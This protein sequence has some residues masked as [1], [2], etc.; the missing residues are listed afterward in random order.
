[1]LEYTLYHK[2]INKI[3]CKFHLS[4]ANPVHM[5]YTCFSFIVSCASLLYWHGHC[6]T[7]SYERK[8]TPF[9]IML[10]YK[11]TQQQLTWRHFRAVIFFLIT[12]HFPMMAR[13]IVYEVYDSICRQ[14]YRS[15]IT[16]LMKLD[17][18][19]IVR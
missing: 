19:R 6:W 16:F 1:M 3:Y 11:Y 8:L 7:N 9:V 13:N 12:K 15:M 2:I 4:K 17:R 18:E 5:W 10:R 14:T